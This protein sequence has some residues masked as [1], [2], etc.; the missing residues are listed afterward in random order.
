MVK[1]PPDEEASDVTA[2]RKP[3]FV[4][5]DPEQAAVSLVVDPLL[6]L[7][8]AACADNTCDLSAQW[9]NYS[10]VLDYNSH[11]FVSLVWLVM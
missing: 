6:I 10:I 5:V 7:V 8:G 2:A 3:V 1:A 9:T 4:H 11:F